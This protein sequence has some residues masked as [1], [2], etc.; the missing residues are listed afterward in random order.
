VPAHQPRERRTAA[1]WVT[2]AGPEPRPLDSVPA[3]LGADGGFLWVDVVRFD[4]VARTLLDDVFRFHPLAIQQCSATSGLPKIHAYRD[5]FFVVLQVPEPGPDGGLR[6]VEQ[7]HFIGHRFLVTVHPNPETG[8]G[9][10]ASFLETEG[11]LQRMEEGRLQPRL[12]TDLA[13][14][15]VAAMCRRMETLVSACAAATSRLEKRVLVGLPR[16]TDHV[17]DE[18]FRIRHELFTV[19]TVVGQSREVYARMLNFSRGQLPEETVAIQDLV[20][21]FDHLRNICD[22][23]KELLQEVLDLFQTRIANDLNA[24]VRRL[25][26]IGSILVFCTLI[27]GVYGM[28]F[29][30]MPELGW[31]YG[32]F[33]ALGVMA[34]SAILGSWYFHR[35]GWL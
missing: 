14:A 21:Q 28:N 12:P 4:V 25:T 5:H 17:L 9:D 30:H 18:M 10:D 6:L 19:R 7:A 27:A 16:D 3:L 34:L 20:D 15:I 22:S 35:K 11:A 29:D 31:R 26:S 1:Y 24:F 2:P 8:L 33:G 23:E 32:Y 13:Q